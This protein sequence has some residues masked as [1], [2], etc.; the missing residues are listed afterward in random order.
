MKK[1]ALISTYCDTPE[2]LNLLQKN[3]SILRSL[4][5]DTFVLSPIKIDVDCD[6][7]FITKENP[8]LRWP[9]RGMV[10]WKTFFYEKREIKTTVVVD[11]YGW[12]SLYQIKKMMDISITYDYDIFYVLIYDLNMDEKV[13]ED[14]KVNSYNKIYPTRDVLGSK[15]FPS[16]LTFA[17]FNKEKLKIMSSLL[18]KNAYK[19]NS[20]VA[21]EFIHQCV[22]AMGL[23]HSDHYVTDLICISNEDRYF[24]HSL[25]KKYDFFL[26][27]DY[28]DNLKILFYRVTDVID[29]YINDELFKI[30]EEQ[31]LETNFTTETLKILKMETD[32]ELIDY[33]DLYNQISKSNINI[34]EYL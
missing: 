2:K 19:I 24:N 7:L 25:S 33:L 15:I 17:S 32:G 29:I 10:A 11:D 1:L 20:W 14:I 27:K 5:V 4:N 18:D 23:E 30:N 12:A 34:I 8:I 22:V 21:E 28:G 9:E 6:F 3:I 26:S 31:L 16:S 13:I